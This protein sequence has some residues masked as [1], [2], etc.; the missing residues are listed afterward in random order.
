MFDDSGTERVQWLDNGQEMKL[1]KGIVPV[2][3]TPFDAG[4]EIDELSLVRLVKATMDGGAAGFLV[5][6]VASEVA[7]LKDRERERLLELV[8]KTVDGRVPVIAGASAD[9]AE[10]CIRHGRAGAKLGA[11]A[12]LVAVPQRCYREPAEALPF[13]ER[14]AAGVDLPLVVQD[15]EWSGPGLDI[16]TIE[17]LAE[18]I[19][20]LAGIKVETVPAGP[21]YT[22][23]RKALG[24]DF[25]ISGGWAAPQMIEA[26]D[27]GVDAMIPE[28]S[29]VVVYAKVFRLYSEGRR[30]DAVGLFRRLLP[31]LAFANQ[32]IRTSIAFFKR[33]LVK[34]GIFE[35]D[36][37]RGEPYEWDK[38]NG[39]IAGELIE[40]YLSLE[41]ECARI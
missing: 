34:K 20:T 22:Q 3:Q 35:N 2:V 40:H 5:P 31:V 21:K 12:W 41:E 14:A 26:L 37:L 13:F 1:R 27:R 9:A 6:A 4:G 28:C 24:G 17:R 30:D 16:R 36:L 39:R 19:P 11:S 38:Y 18:R 15:L 32:E 8:L 33:L 25:Y 10:E 7:M 29:M 23:V